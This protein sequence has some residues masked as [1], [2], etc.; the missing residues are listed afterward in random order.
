MDKNIK[1]FVV[2]VSSLGSK[3]TIHPAKEAQL[4]L[5]LA[6]KVTILV[7]YSDFAN[8]FSEELANILRKQT[9][10]NKHA[11]KLEGGK[12]L[13]YGHI[14]S[15]R[16]VELKTFKIYIETNLANGFIRALKSLAGAP[17]LFVRKSNS[18]LCLCVN[19]QGLK[20]LIIKNWYPLLLIGKSLD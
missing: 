9:G 3:M 17:I 1:A 5:L 18:S 14:Y 2:H 13:P 19:Y 15:L 8:V 4:A 10:V 20:N 6:K 11:I 12:Q 7:K 16:P